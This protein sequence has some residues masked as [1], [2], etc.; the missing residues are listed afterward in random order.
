M[1][2]ICEICDTEKATVKVW[3][4]ASSP[5]T[6]LDAC[7]TCAKIEVF[8]IVPPKVLKIMERIE[9]DLSKRLSFRLKEDLFQMLNKGYEGWL[10]DRLEANI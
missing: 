1:P 8:P 9:K 5:S 7:E 3:V 10:R 6:I 4:E 2:N